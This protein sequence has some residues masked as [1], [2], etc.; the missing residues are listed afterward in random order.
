[1]GG[2]CGVKEFQMQ[3]VRNE[4][5]KIRNFGGGNLEEVFGNLSRR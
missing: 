4:E 2:I 5:E 1:V 3:G